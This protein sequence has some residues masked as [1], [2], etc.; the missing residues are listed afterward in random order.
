MLNNPISIALRANIG[1]F[2]ISIQY[3]IH[4]DDDI[5]FNMQK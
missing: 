5:I 1:V 3:F 2:S 4:N